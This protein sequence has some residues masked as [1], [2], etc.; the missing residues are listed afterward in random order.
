MRMLSKVR[1]AWD[2]K[3]ASP[4]FSRL[5]YFGDA[6]LNCS[7]EV[8][9]DLAAWVCPPGPSAQVVLVRSNAFI[10][11]IHCRRSIGR[12]SRNAMGEPGNGSPPPRFM[13]PLTARL[14]NAVA[15]PHE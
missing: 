7:P 4:P 2:S 10:A 6:L 11:S 5:F 14:F 8:R 3:R 12:E 13:N 1:R 15:R 9:F